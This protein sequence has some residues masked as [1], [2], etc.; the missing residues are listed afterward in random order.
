MAKLIPPSTPFAGVQVS[1]EE[2]KYIVLG[3][4]YDSTST[5]R[6]GSRFAPQALRQASL[7]IETY[8][9]RTGLFLEELK[10]RDIGDLDVSS[11]GNPFEEL[12]NLLSKLLEKGKIPIVLGGE[13]TLTY[14]AVKA[15]PEDVAVIIFDAHL[16]LRN[17]YEGKTFSHTTYLRRLSEE[18][19]PERFLILG[20]RAVCAEELEYASKAG[21]KYLDMKAMRNLDVDRAAQ[22]VKSRLKDFSG[23]YVSFDMD[24]LDPS[25]A[26][27]ASNPEPEG[28]TPTFAL[29][30]LQQLFSSFPRVLGFDLVE[31]SPSYDNGVTAIL[32][33]KIVFEALCLMEAAL[34]KQI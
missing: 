16:D 10:I 15:L 32:G 19:S 14:S 7:N 23:V 31:F 29:N 20:V 11:A 9:L 25:Y 2:A 4:P 5:Y 8:S 27:A 21:I 17:R 18:T 24:V 12:K 13:H 28:L 1:P 34:G 6:F 22:E 30:L 3:F 33:A 26:P